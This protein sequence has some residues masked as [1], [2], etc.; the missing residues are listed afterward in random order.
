MQIG[1]A[2]SALQPIGR[3]IDAT[4]EGI[5]AQFGHPEV[6]G[7]AV[8]ETTTHIKPLPELGL[9]IASLEDQDLGPTVQPVPKSSPSRSTIHN[10]PEANDTKG[11]KLGSK[12]RLIAIV[13][14]LRELQFDLLSVYHWLLAP[15]FAQM[16]DLLRDENTWAEKNHKLFP[17]VLFQ[18]IRIASAYSLT[19]QFYY[20]S[21]LFSTIIPRIISL[22]DSQYGMEKA[23]ALL[24]SP[25][26]ISSSNFRVLVWP[27]W[28]QQFNTYHEALAEMTQRP[29]I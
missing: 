24:K 22:A 21:Y 25:S 26:I 20:A 7:K 5:V 29:D 9:C 6:D 12:K 17:S 27:I 16:L 11:L 18:A 2:G 3:T 19:D 4:S 13:E 10:P 23:E 8:M 14:S 1:H 15:R 28:F